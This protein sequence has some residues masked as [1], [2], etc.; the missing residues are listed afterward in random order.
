MDVQA[1]LATR[2]Q[3]A[4]EQFVLRLP[5]GMRDEI[6]RLSAANRRSMNAEMVVLLESGIRRHAQ[7]HSQ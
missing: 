6:R 1:P 3:R 4:G 7:E 5:V 2:P